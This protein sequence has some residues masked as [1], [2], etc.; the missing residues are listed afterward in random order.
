MIIFV[1]I[2][3]VRSVEI[4][5]GG[6]VFIVDKVDHQWFLLSKCGP[7]KSDWYCTSCQ[8]RHFITFL[9]FNIFVT[10]IEPGYVATLC[11]GWTLGQ[12]QLALVNIT[13]NGTLT[14]SS[15]A[16]LTVTAVTTIEIDTHLTRFAQSNA[17]HFAFV[18]VDTGPF[19]RG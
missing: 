13:A 12:A 10:L 4:I 6:N 15:I 18:I 1:S 11:P 16:L 9:D 5:F 17:V 7:V 2:S 19:I 3:G 8:L 14:L